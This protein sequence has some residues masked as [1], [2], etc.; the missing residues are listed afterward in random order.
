[1]A[2]TT[3]SEPETPPVP[4]ASFVDW[5]TDDFLPRHGRTAGWVLGVVVLGVVGY[6]VAS[7]QKHA[8]EIAANRELGEGLVAFS[9]EDPAKAVAAFQTYL[10]S[11]NAK[12]SAEQKAELLMAK[13]LYRQGKW[14]E[15]YQAY[16][17]VGQPAE[18]PLLGAAALHGM[19]A[20]R[21][22]TKAY[23]QAVPLLEKLV[24][25]YMR[26]SGKPTDDLA[27]E[28]VADLSPVIPNALWKLA[29]CRRELGNQEAA[30]EAAKKLVAAYP[31]SREAQ[32]ASRFLALL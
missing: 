18:M 25:D 14:E 8:A 2:K 31:A 9:S 6:F 12:G 4:A 23:D 32:E 19:A 26:R 27:G 24:S 3:S 16:E 21:M 1:M 15:A 13:S 17:K 20:C 10:Q 5:V 22:Q 30:R 28:E 29:L 11:G 7:K